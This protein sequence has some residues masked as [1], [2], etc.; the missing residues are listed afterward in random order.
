MKTNQI[1]LT[2]FLLF[3]VTF[4]CKQTDMVEIATPISTISGK[5]KLIEIFKGDVIDRPCGI[6]PPT[7][8]ITLEFTANPS[9]MDDLLSLSGQSTVN[10][11]FGNYKADSKG[12]IKITTLGGTKRGGSPEMMQ[13]ENNYYSLLAASEAYKIVQIQT[14]P[15]KTV[16]QLGV[17]RNGIKDGGN[18]LIFEKVN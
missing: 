11:Y 17:F 13:C 8:D 10:E 1:I 7:R 18:Y 12:A 15:V 6:N 2:L 5:W 4:S 3:A 9:G 14:N 16:L